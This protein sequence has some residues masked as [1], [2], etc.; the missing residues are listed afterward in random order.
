MI[1][2]K[3]FSEKY[4][5]S[6]ISLNFDTY[7]RDDKGKNFKLPNSYKKKTFAITAGNGIGLFSCCEI[8]F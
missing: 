6:T 4:N 2:F 8:C 3:I 7:F 5:I 1:I